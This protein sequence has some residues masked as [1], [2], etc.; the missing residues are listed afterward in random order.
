VAER[1][2]EYFARLP[3]VK[4]P[5]IAHGNALSIDWNQVVPRE[6][7]SFI[8]GNPPF[9]GAKMMTPTQREDL[10]AIAGNLKGAGLLDFV[11]AWYLKAA[12]YLQG[13]GSYVRCAFVSTNSITQGEQVGVLWAEML[14][15]GLRI[16]FAHR[17]FTWSNEARGVAAVHCVII[18]FSAQDIR[19]KRLFDYATIKSD[20]QELIASNINPYLVDAADVLLPN[21][22]KPICDVPSIGIGNKPIDGGNYLFSTEE[23]DAFIAAEPAA[24]P[25]FRRWL[26]AAEFINGWERWCLWLGECPPDVLRQLPLSMQRVQ[27]VREFRLASKSA[28]TRKIASTPTRF[29]VENIPDSSFLMIP[30]VSS[31][32]RP[33]IPVGFIDAKTFVSDSALI[34]Q[35]ALIYHFGIL[36]STMHMAWVRAVCGRLKSDYRYS[37][38]IVYNNFPWPELTPQTAVA[39]EIGREQGPIKAVNKYSNAIEAAAQGVLEARASFPNSTLADLYDPLT[40]P[41]ALV[42]AHQALD[43]AVDAAYIAAEKAAGRKPPKIGS[44]AE[45]VAFLFQ[46]YQVLTSLLPTGKPARN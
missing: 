20:P 43:R 6:R 19:P 36:N 14:R 15:H 11:T 33:Q 41:P 29:H 21:R 4:S 40:M 24:A 5:T 7:L 1:F 3:L 32:R 38:G 16:F 31:E 39:G 17:T 27:A 23:R 10:L 30:R 8:L 18:G 37:A 28:P 44:D 42:K 35:H 2:G 46:R 26:G 13:E 25:W 45:R 9:I 12:Q 22:S 34:G